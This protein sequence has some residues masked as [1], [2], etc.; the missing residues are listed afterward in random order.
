M[1]GSDPDHLALKQSLGSAAK[2]TRYDYNL[3]ELRYSL[4]SLDHHLPWFK[5]NIYI[6]TPGQTPS[7]L[8]TTNP[9]IKIINQ[10][11]ILP[12]EALPTCN[13][14]LLEF[15]LDRIPGLSEKFI[16]MNDDYFFLSETTPHDLFT[17]DGRVKS[18][19]N[20]PPRTATIGDF[21]AHDNRLGRMKNILGTDREHDHIWQTSMSWTILEVTRILNATTVSFYHV[22]FVWER[23]VV[24]QI[25]LDFNQSLTGMYQHKFRHWRD[26]QA[27][28]V[29]Y[30]KYQAMSRG[31]E[32]AASEPINPSLTRRFALF[33]GC[34]DK[35][36]EAQTFERHAKWGRYKF[37]NMNSNFEHAES[38]GFCRQVL[39][40]MFAGVSPYELADVSEDLELLPEGEKPPVALHRPAAPGPAK[41]RLPPTR[42]DDTTTHS[43]VSDTKMDAAIEAAEQ[44]E[45]VV[46]TLDAKQAEAA[47]KAILEA[48]APGPKVTVTAP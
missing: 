8:N 13:A 40:R 25:R 41:I 3:N 43:T 5:G 35:I 32:K 38:A 20:S 22:P 46:T 12:K 44:Y 45:P 17:D 18:F 15:Y 39:S 11:D 48:M 16:Y 37:G 2:A 30:S 33:G 7:W 24:E 23:S 9:R 21:T 6:V 31:Q 19:P 4:R 29:I 47:A 1:N 42:F 10:D 28:S 14:F 36:S 27:P 26:L 34:G